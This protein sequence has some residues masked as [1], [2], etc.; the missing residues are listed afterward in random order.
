MFDGNDMTQYAKSFLVA[1]LVCLLA[2]VLILS[3][4]RVPDISH[5]YLKFGDTSVDVSLIAFVTSLL[6]VKLLFFAAY[7]L[8]VIQ[9]F[10]THWGWGIAN[11]LLSPLAALVFLFVHPK[12]A[13][14]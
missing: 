10:R 12:H 1:A 11:L 7:I 8:F 6:S 13:K 5:H 14:L 2:V 4:A 9:G 3:I